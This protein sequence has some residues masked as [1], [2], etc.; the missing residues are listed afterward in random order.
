[1]SAT[2]ILHHDN[3]AHAAAVARGTAIAN[4]ADL[5]PGDVL[6]SRW[7][8]GRYMTV[9]APAR[10]FCGYLAVAYQTEDGRCGTLNVRADVNPFATR[11]SFPAPEPGMNSLPEPCRKFSPTVSV[12]HSGACGVC[13]WRH[14]GHPTSNPWPKTPAMTRA[15][16]EY[17]A[18]ILFEASREEAIE[19]P[20][21]VERIAGKFAYHLADTN[22]RFDRD[23][24]I[25]A[26]TA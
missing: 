20:M 15:H 13:G 10:F 22:G 3:P 7:A 4:P 18:R 2:I 25:G 23:R 21:T 14:D 1:M 12:G 9:T 17:L 6:L 16:F 26:A 8:P 11:P 5:L 19:G 24:F